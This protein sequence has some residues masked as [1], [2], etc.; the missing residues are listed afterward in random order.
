VL[1]QRPC[2]NC[3]EPK[4]RVVVHFVEEPL[5]LRDEL[6][7]HGVNPREEL[8][9]E[10]LTRTDGNTEATL[11]TGLGS[12]SMFSALISAAA[13]AIEVPDLRRKFR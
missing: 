3:R 5:E 8:M 10:R 4:F 11:A 7:A 9:L 6:D 12:P 2:V 1:G 13:F